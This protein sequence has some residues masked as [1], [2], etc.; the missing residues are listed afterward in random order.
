MTIEIYETTKIYIVAPAA[1]ATGGPELLHQLAFHMRNTLGIDAYMY[2]IP[3]HKCDPVHPE[4]QMYSNPYVKDI[5]DVEVNLIIVPEVKYAIDILNNYKRIRKAIWWLSVDNFFVSWTLSS[6]KKFFFERSLNKLSQLISGRHVFDTRELV[7]RRI[8]M[9]LSYLERVKSVKYHLAQSY[10][11]MDFLIRNGIPPQDVF[12]LSD[13]LNEKFLSTEVPLYK[14]ENVVVYNPQKGFLF[15]KKLMD[16]SRDIKFVPLVNMTRSQVIDTLKKAKVYIDFGN[17]P[18]KDRIPREAAILGC[19]VITGKRGSARYFGD[20]PIP[21][22]YKFEDK[23]E[24]IPRIIEKIKDCFINFEDRYRDFG[25]YRKYIKEEFK[26]FLSD[27]K[28]L[29]VKVKK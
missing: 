29:F 27:M 5:E 20:V 19:C 17:H 12:Y 11:A 22:E 26:N 28:K 15:T 3:S 16:F 9:H 21:D 10:Y 14:K 24:N 25:Y 4:Y 6:K 13:Y 2:Y 1:T 8:G 23:I 7:L 18:G